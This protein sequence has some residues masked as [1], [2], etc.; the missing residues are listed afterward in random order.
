MDR[1]AS[2][3]DVVRQAKHAD[4]DFMDRLHF[5]TTVYILICCALAIFAKEYGGDP[6]QCW[7]QPEWIPAWIEYAH[8]LCFVENTYYINPN[9]TLMSNDGD[10]YKKNDEIKYYQWMPFVLVGQAFAFYLPY[11]LWRTCNRASGLHLRALVTMARTAERV[12]LGLTSEKRIRIAGYIFQSF[13]QQHDAYNPDDDC[14]L[15]SRLWGRFLAILRQ[16]GGVYRL[17]FL[18]CF[19]KCL[20][21]AVSYLQLIFI[22][23]FLGTKAS[24]F[25]FNNLPAIRGGDTW[26]TTGLF[27]RI[28]MCDFEVRAMGNQVV[29]HTVQCVLM[30]NMINE[31]IFNGVWWWL[32]ALIILG[33][34]NL[35]HWLI[36][37]FIP[38]KQ[39]SFIEECVMEG[40]AMNDGIVEKE[41]EDVDKKK[42]KKLER[43]RRALEQSRPIRQPTTL[44]SPKMSSTLRHRHNDS[45]I[46]T[47]TLNSSSTM[48]ND[49]PLTDEQ[50]TR[51]EE[52]LFQCLIRMNESA[53]QDDDQGPKFHVYDP[54][55]IDKFLRFIGPDGVLLFR[56]MQIN[57][58]MM[59]TSQ[60]A[61]QVYHDFYVDSYANELSQYTVGS[62]DATDTPSTE[63]SL[64]QTPGT[65]S[66][67]T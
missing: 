40:N 46:T 42:R 11:L 28:T 41:R 4:E 34:M 43:Q 23:Q 39:L 49:L 21:I 53:N 6:I 5:R 32:S 60:I 27:P 67:C 55:R 30:A 56:L 51:L 44:T 47:D 20:F 3:L 29:K 9:K 18:Y 58:S 2:F 54:R 33:K 15:L 8:D 48:Y 10:R 50:L 17:T 26:E 24:L 59:V 16:N 1:V 52:T 25:G 19:T 65:A 37:L 64:G 7:Q 14:C 57:S 12:E 45:G 63:N 61:A 31:K 62:D 66:T 35:I 13:K 38:S 36:V 22:S